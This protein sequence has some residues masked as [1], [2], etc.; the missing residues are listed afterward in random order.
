ML[1]ECFPTVE[2]CGAVRRLR[3][4][5]ASPFYIALIVLLMV[6]ANLFT[7]ELPVFYCY[8][9]AGL[10]AVLFGDDLSGIMP[11]ACCAY[12]TISV[13]SNN[14]ASADMA[15]TSALYRPEFILQLIFLIVAA[16]LLIAGRLAVMLMRGEKRG[17]PALTLGFAAF[18]LSLVLGGLFSP[19]YDLRTVIFALAITASL[20]ALYFL[21]YYGVDWRKIGKDYF[22]Q[23]FLMIG[24]GVI[25]ELVG[26]YLKSGILMKPG[27]DRGIIVTGWG[28]YSNVGCV[29]AMCLPAPLYFAAVKRHG[30]VFLLAALALM[31]GLVFTQSRGSILFGAIVFAIG[32]V[33]VLIFTKGRERVNHLIVLAAVGIAAVVL[34]LVLWEK[35]LPLFESM[36]NTFGEGADLSNG[37][38]PIYEEGI[39]HFTEAPFFGVGFYQCTAFRWGNLPK[40]AFL[41]PRYHNTFIQ[42]MATGGIVA[43]VCYL[44]H[45]LETIF[46]LFAHPTKEKAFLALC[47]LGLLLTSTVECHFFSFGPGLLYSV[48]LVCAEGQPE[49]VPPEIG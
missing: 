43:L 45:R 34:C 48:L 35:L 42:C 33:L 3:A 37:R 7:L 49:A 41:P 32:L 31:V 38:G 26:I 15:G 20:C 29:L 46:L 10:L 27:V 1:I 17:M 9:V 30:W 36:L 47:I 2:Q 25:A 13:E 5:L 16:L 19:Y 4:F 18:G 39:R 14:P 24:F 11:I 44:L 12:M 23:L 40:D 22:A 28:M 21:F 8:L 6:T